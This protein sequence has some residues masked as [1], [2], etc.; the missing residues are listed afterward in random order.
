MSNHDVPPLVERST[1]SPATANAAARG[2]VPA[3]RLVT[4]VRHGSDH[5]RSQFAPPS[6]DTHI[7]PF[8]VPAQS[9][10]PMAKALIA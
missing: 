4:A 1:R 8:E 2:P 6:G 9:L 10:S 3:H 7:C 5:S